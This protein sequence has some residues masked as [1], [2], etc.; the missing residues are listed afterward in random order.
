MTANIQSGSGYQHSYAVYIQHHNLNSL[1]LEKV[2]EL[3]KL[4]GFY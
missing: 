4:K 1:I 2:K 3:M